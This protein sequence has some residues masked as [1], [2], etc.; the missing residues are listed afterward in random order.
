MMKSSKTRLANVMRALTATIGLTILASPVFADT[1]PVIEQATCQKIAETLLL[2]KIEKT[3]NDSANEVLEALAHSCGLNENSKFRFQDLQPIFLRFQEPKLSILWNGQ[4]VSINEKAEATLE[5]TMPQNFSRSFNIEPEAILEAP[6]LP[7]PIYHD[8][9]TPNL[10]PQVCG[11]MVQCLKERIGVYHEHV[12]EL[13]RKGQTNI[14]FSGIAHHDRNTY[15]P[16]K[17]RELNEKAWGIGIERIRYTEKGNREGVA[18]VVISDSHADPQV[19]LSYEHQK[20]VYNGRLMSAYVGLTGGLVARSDFKYVPLPFVFP[21]ATVRIGKINLKSI[22]IPK[23]GGG[24]NSGAVLF[25]F[26]STPI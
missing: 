6:P 14:I 1:K 11:G 23:I 19:S 13:N 12:R 10:R 5:F 20:R 7:T 18:L 9:S 21:S 17:L 24:V 26:A 22:Y 2:G 4:N 15:T 16:E 8:G 3:K 25:L